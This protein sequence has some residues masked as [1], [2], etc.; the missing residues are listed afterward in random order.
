L[1]TGSNFVSHIFKGG[2]KWGSKGAQNE[3]QLKELK[4][5]ALYLVIDE[6]LGDD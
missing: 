4:I 2:A 1:L 3:E 6:K 5:D